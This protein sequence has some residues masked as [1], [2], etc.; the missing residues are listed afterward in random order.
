MSAHAYGQAIDINPQ[1]NPYIN[2]DG[3]CSHSNAKQ[4][5]TGRDKKMAGLIQLRQ[6]VLH[7]ILKFI[8]FL[9]S[10]D[11]HGL[12]IQIIL[13]IHNIFKKLI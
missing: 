8:R 12:E 3:T 2:S 5:A 4:Y 13:V 6:H 7:K 1:I 11:G 10:M 9:Q